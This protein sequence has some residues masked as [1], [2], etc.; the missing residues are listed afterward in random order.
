MLS[1]ILTLILTLIPNLKHN[2][3]L[4]PDPISV[5]S[6]IFASEVNGYVNIRHLPF[7]VSIDVNV[8]LLKHIFVKSEPCRTMQSNVMYQFSNSMNSFL[9]FD[10][11]KISGKWTTHINGNATKETSNLFFCFIYYRESQR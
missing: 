10:I 1:I 11:K 8:K 7:L 5:L 4:N 2:T 9:P 3:N 6:Q